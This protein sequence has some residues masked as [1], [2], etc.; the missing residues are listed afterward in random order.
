MEDLQEECFPV[1]GF[2]TSDRYRLPLYSADTYVEVEVKAIGNGLS[3]SAFSAIV[4]P[5]TQSNVTTIATAG[6]NGSAFVQNVDN[7]HHT[8]TLTDLATAD[9]NATT[10]LNQG[11]ESTDGSTQAYEF[12][13]HNDSTRITGALATGDYLRVVAANGSTTATY[14][15]TVAAEAAVCTG[16]TCEKTYSATCHPQ[17]FEAPKGVTAI[18]FYALGAGGGGMSGS[19][20]TS[21]GGEGGSVDTTLSVHPGE[22]FTLDVGGGGSGNSGSSGVAGGCFG[23]GGVGKAEEAGGSGGGGSFVAEGSTLLIAAGGGGGAQIVANGGSG[24]KT[25][26]N[27]GANGSA[28]LG[29]GGA[30]SSA[31]GAGGSGSPSGLPGSGPATATEPGEGGEAPTSGA[32]R[33][34]GG[35]GGGY[36]GGGSG[37]SDGGSGD[38]GGGGGSDHA[39]FSGTNTT[40]DTTRAAGG[41]GSQNGDNGRIVVRYTTIPTAAPTLKA[42]TTSESSKSPLVVTFQLPEEAA[43]NSLSLTFV[44]GGT[45]TTVK[46]AASE[47]TEGEHTISLQ[48]HDLKANPSEVAS[49]TANELPDGTY[50]LTISY[51]NPEESPAA[52]A[53]VTG[54]KIKTVTTAPTLMTPTT[55]SELHGDF[56]V[57]YSLPEAMLN[58]SLQLVFYSKSVGTRTLTLS[59]VPPGTHT[60]TIDPL[61]P[62]NEPGVSSGAKSIPYGTYSI[63]VEY[64]DELGNPVAEST[65]AGV[66]LKAP[67]CQPGFYS[68]TTEEP[69]TEASPGHY[70]EGTGA[71]TQTPCEAGTYNPN[72]GS[73][74]GADCLQASLGNYVELIGQSTEQECAIGTFASIIHSEVCVEAEPGHYVAHSGSASQQECVAGT[75]SERTEATTC[76]TTPEGNYSA[77]GATTPIPCDPGTNDPHT[78]STSSAACE[79]DAAGSYS[80]AG[81]SSATLCDAGTSNSN[82]GSTTSAA[83][84]LDVAGSWSAPGA[85]TATLCAAGTYNPNNGSTSSA[86]CTPAGLGH[87]VSQAGSANQQECV[88]GMYSEHTGSSDCEEAEAGHYVSA[89][90]ASAQTE[91]PAG[92]YSSLARATRCTTTPMNT[93]S[94]NGAI[95][96]TPCPTGTEAPAGSVACTAIPKTEL[97]TEVKVETKVETPTTTTTTP[98]V[99]QPAKGHEVTPI[100]TK[101]KLN[102]LCV[103][104]GT[105]I[106]NGSE[107]K[108]LNLSLRLNEAASIEYKIAPG[109]GAA[110]STKCPRGKGHSKTAHEKVWTGPHIASKGKKKHEVAPAKAPLALTAG[111]H[112]VSLAAALAAAH[113]NAKHLRP[114]N[115]VLT[116]IAVNAEGKRSIATTVK[117]WIIEPH[118]RVR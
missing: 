49:A 31:V 59:D 28:S 75:Y 81:A 23:G 35:G 103:A 47:L 48:T 79:L 63:T 46:P 55:G 71:T 27:G 98:P 62:E 9:T 34:G 101:L 19:G 70:T 104:P 52:S 78:N 74:S 100:I 92:T 97:K 77:T 22:V 115:Y 10:G 88:A 29:G 1:T 4:G 96:P 76:S 85:A 8:I 116:V 26:G 67:L 83:C 6:S 95:E 39:T 90:G 37:A 24:G 42:P 94:S 54:V 110:K 65:V 21:N 105:L 93:Y 64:Q 50:S 44:D 117:F 86:A 66:T 87:Y 108:G 51:Q 53:S 57:T 89:H 69:C 12:Y 60:V 33:G 61:A 82:T 15:I 109:K 3:G 40:Y 13:A 118:P 91:C 18:T 45:I 30:T 58:N 56:G 2:S 72:N 41:V 106:A 25:A 43:P 114:G 14:E 107:A 102:H 113:F 68:A 111:S 16:T 38:G 7:T 32:Q 80:G 17:S 99:Q 20:A 84:E 73:T 112:Q 11:L 36:Y 5:V